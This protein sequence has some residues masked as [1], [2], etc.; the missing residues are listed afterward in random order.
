MIVQKVLMSFM[1]GL[2]KNIPQWWRELCP[3]KAC[4]P[5]DECSWTQ[6]STLRFVQH[7]W[8]SAIHFWKR[9]AFFFRNHLRWEP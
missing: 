7:L 3:A 8:E 4:V 5:V 6:Q 9:K 1:P 2:W